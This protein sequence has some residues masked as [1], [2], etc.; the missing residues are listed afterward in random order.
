MPIKCP[1]NQKSSCRYRKIKGGKQ[2]LCGC[3]K[4]G[5]FVKIKEIKT[6][7]KGKV[8][9]DYVKHTGFSKSKCF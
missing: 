9:F 1:K 5:K 7:K 2:R 4:K 3:M 8:K 6:I